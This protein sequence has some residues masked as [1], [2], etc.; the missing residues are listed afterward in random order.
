MGKDRRDRNERY[1]QR[2]ERQR[3]RR[4]K[5]EKKSRSCCANCLITLVVLFIFSLGLLYGGGMFAWNQYAKPMFGIS[6]ND[7]LG[8]VG[9]TYIAKEK[10]IVTNPYKDEDVDGFYNELS[11]ALFLDDSVNLRE[12]LSAVLDSYIATMMDKD[13]STSGNDE[14]LSTEGE[15]GG[16]SSGSFSTGNEAL[17]NFLKALKFDFSSLKDYQDEYATPHVLEVTDKQTAAFLNNTIKSAAN[18]EAFSTIL[19]DF[20]K[21]VKLGDI[22]DI[23]QIIVT[24][25][26]AV[27]L[28]N[29]ALTLTVKVNLRKTVK[30][31]AQNFHKL[32]GPL[33]GIVPKALYATITIYPNDYLKG[34]QIK[35]NSFSD[36]KM[37]DLYSVANYFLKDS[38]YKSIDGIL[39]MVNQ[40][41]V[42]A[43]EK[44]QSLVPINFVATGS[45]EV[46]PIKALMTALKATD[47]TETQFYCMIRDLCLPT[48]DEVKGNMG[49]DELDIEKVED[50]APYIQNA[51]GELVDEI[52]LKYGIE[53]G[54]LNADNMLD[55][56]KSVGGESSELI[57]KVSLSRLNFS[58][59]MYIQQNARVGVK[60]AGLA[61][62]LDGYLNNASGEGL[63]IEYKII[64]AMYE[65]ER[66]KLSLVLQ[67]GILD[68]ITQKMEEGSILKSFV[69]QLIPKYIYI[70]A[71]V[72]LNDDA[73]NVA[74][75]AINK[76]SEAETQALLDTIGSLTSGMG[77]SMGLNY[78]ELT[79][80]I[81]T[82][83]KDGIKDIDT[84]LGTSI[85]FTE[86]KAYL[87]SV[88][89]IM[90]NKILYKEEVGADNLTP[91]EVYDVFK[92]ACEINNSYKGQDI[93]SDLTAFTTRVNTRYAL[94]QYVNPEDATDVTDYRLTV[95][96]EDDT[97]NT[98][99]KQLQKIGG[100]HDKA[101]NGIELADSWKSATALATTNEQKLQI[102]HEEFSPYATEAEAAKIF[103][104]AFKINTTGVKGITLNKVMIFVDPIDNIAKLRLIYTCEYDTTESTKYTSVLPDFVINVVFDLTKVETDDP[105]CNVTIN[106]MSEEEIHNFSLMCERLGITGFNIDTIRANTNTAVK[107]GLREMF[108]KVEISIDTNAETKGIYFGSL[109]DVTYKNRKDAIDAEIADATALDVANTIAALHTGIESYGQKDVVK[110]LTSEEFAAFPTNSL[111]KYVREASG[112][113]VAGLWEANTAYYEKVG[114]DYI[115]VTDIFDANRDLLISLQVPPTPSTLDAALTAR[116]IGSAVLSADMS[117][118]LT[119]VGIQNLHLHQ[120]VT[121]DL[122]SSDPDIQAKNALLKNSLSNLITATSGQYIVISFDI[123]TSELSY[124]SSLLPEHLYLTA[125]LRNDTAADNIA[126]EYN[127]MS[128]REIEVLKALA[129]TSGDSF[130]TAA[131][132]QKMRQSLYD[133][134]L[135]TF[136]DVPYT[137]GMVLNAN[138]GTISENIDTND[139]ING[140][141]NIHFEL[142][143]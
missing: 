99:V 31:V 87:P 133:V 63:N 115:P 95:P 27:G 53:E 120:S 56:L 123:I 70:K 72:C 2:R 22:V 113:A 118:M 23:P 67:L 128:Q 45:V 79:S 102:M 76:S 130:D 16:S 91:S 55:Q 90:A 77:V 122:G 80:T 8:L 125:T 69:G 104:D 60:Y 100:A 124:K 139:L 6:F 65:E 36:K 12:N 13:N 30:T 11:E 141:Y 134:T 92:G 74:Q 7:A 17:D 138:A 82:K 48:F 143:V 39:Q 43:I 71:S 42:E 93:E 9:S 58:D 83:V 38:Q 98:I 114:S 96:A 140:A 15:E 40:K 75:V 66:N 73:E 21:D 110:A 107:D 41:A 29:V 142:S 136:K 112:Y 78:T 97:E 57:D 101:I 89:E 94:Q 35:V 64:N 5:E 119:Q 34:A 62:L 127:N 4:R 3:K 49:F 51:K 116:N 68:V 33:A 61:G 32:L 52:A 85:T 132:A 54:Y 37:A 129:G 81:G 24:S 105:C 18:N 106:D 108:N 10:D 135:F 25:D 111:Y 84:K 14:A 26:T 117:L 131:V 59:G 28:E 86:E 103:G 126:I 46:H 20:A 19:P 50:I 121:L 44:V 88:Y 137:L 47:V 109:F 1:S